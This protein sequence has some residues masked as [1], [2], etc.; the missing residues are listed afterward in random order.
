MSNAM[1]DILNKCLNFAQPCLFCGARSLAGLACPDCAATLP[2]LPAERCPHCAL[3]T[4]GG[5]LCGACLKRPPTFDRSH[6]VFSYRFPA[7]VAIQRLKYHGELAIARWLADEMAAGLGAGDRPQL[8]VPMPLHPRR[9]SERGFNQ[10]A[11]LAQH[12]GQRLHIPQ[13]VTVCRR[14]RDTPP[15][16]ALP[17]AERRRNIRGAF[18]CDSRLAGLRIALVD[19]VMTSGASLDEL[20]KAAK[21]AGAR[22]VEAWVIARTVNT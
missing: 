20:A 3:P 11:L 19:D 15:Q 7:D 18:S 9:L 14:V 13:A 4:L 2:R 5:A 12:L 6:A 8:L 16:V 1:T 10:A 21:R 22:A 17:L